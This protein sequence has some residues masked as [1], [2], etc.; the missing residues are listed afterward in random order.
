MTRNGEGETGNEEHSSSSEDVDPISKAI[1]TCTVVDPQKLQISRF[2]SKGHLNVSSSRVRDLCKERY[3][4]D[5]IIEPEIYKRPVEERD[6]F[7]ERR[8]QI[9]KEF[10]EM[11]EPQ[12]ARHLFNDFLYTPIFYKYFGTEEEK[13]K[14]KER[15]KKEEM[16]RKKKEKRDLKEMKA[17]KAKKEKEPVE[18]LPKR[19]RRN[20]IDV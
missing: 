11:L 13:K 4:A 1:A 10:D 14:D 15:R 16:E 9:S 7:Y 12:V 20:V 6:A 17:K 18:R 8:A 3:Y 19:A 5:K 2:A